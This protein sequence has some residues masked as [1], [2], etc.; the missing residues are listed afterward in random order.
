MSLPAL[1]YLGEYK[2]RCR[3]SEVTAAPWTGLMLNGWVEVET[4]ARGLP[5]N[6]FVRLLNDEKFSIGVCN[7]THTFLSR[8]RKDG[9]SCWASGVM[10]PSP[11]RCFLPYAIYVYRRRGGPGFLSKQVAEQLYLSSVRDFLEFW[12]CS[13]SAVHVDLAPRPCHPTAYRHVY[14]NIDQ[15]SALPPSTAGALMF[16]LNHESAAC[17]QTAYIFGMN[18]VRLGNSEYTFARTEG[19]RTRIERNKPP[20]PAA[21]Q[22]LRGCLVIGQTGVALMQV[23]REWLKV[24]PQGPTVVVCRKQEVPSVTKALADSGEPF[25]TILKAADF[26]GTS[27][28]ANVVLLSVDCLYRLGADGQERF[29]HFCLRG[30]AR[31]V[32]VGWPDLQDE[33]ESLDCRIP[34]KF[35]ASLCLAEE[36]DLSIMDTETIE[37]MLGLPSRTLQDHA[38]DAYTV[39]QRIYYLVNE[40]SPARGHRGPE[41]QDACEA[42]EGPALSPSERF[43]L[44][45]LRGEKRMMHLVF[46]DLSD[47]LP[48]AKRP[49]VNL[50]A[51]ETFLGHFAQ[52]GVP[53][54]HF[55]ETQLLVSS[56]DGQECPICFEPTTEVATSCGHFFC[57]RCLQTCLVAAHRRCPTCRR[58]LQKLD[59]VSVTTPTPAL[60]EHLQ[61]LFDY[62]QSRQNEKVVVLASWPAM[63]ERL[64]ARYRR[65]GLERCWAWHGNAER[66]SFVHKQFQ[67]A[68]GG[69]LFVDPDYL[70]WEH[71]EGVAQ[72]LVLWPL[73]DHTGGELCCQITKARGA[74]PHAPLRLLARGGEEPPPNIV[75]TCRHA[76]PL[77]P[78]CRPLT[79]FSRRNGAAPN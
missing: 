30:W 19:N 37:I 41:S 53:V 68:K 8:C 79:V 55:A 2:C 66:L 52:L 71:F 63:H 24:F 62:L 78:A 50:R 36:L 61:F 49:R 3:I 56:L 47:D 64:T 18:A 43:K 60:G 51:G 74:F 67:M 57:E 17:S 72:L 15:L 35:M 45:D 14:D 9:S 29:R 33:L 32:C 77:A 26:E 1:S 59:L 44:E 69:C 13:P 34:C 4:D 40:E 10:L 76:H 75:V 20:A 21:A 73:S 7:A 31:L 5:L 16:L 58:P 46:G 70:A 39:K 27:P 22:L 38:A 6:W 12:C 28:A 11:I 23:L 65:L 54:T 48:F 25:E 42:L